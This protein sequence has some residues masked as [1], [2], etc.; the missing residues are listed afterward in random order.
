[1][2]HDRTGRLELSLE[3]QDRAPSLAAVLV[4]QQ[5]D[6]LV[7]ADWLPATRA[8]QLSHAVTV[9]HGPGLAIGGQYGVRSVVCRTLW[10]CA[11]VNTADGAAEATRQLWALGRGDG[12]TIT[13]TK[14]LQELQDG[15]FAYLQPRGQWGYSNAGLI[16]GDDGSLLVDTL[17]DL[18]LTRDMLEEMKPITAT[19]PIGSVVNT[20]ANG[21]HCFGN[22]LVPDRATIYATVAATAEMDEAPPALLDAMKHAPDEEIAAFARHAFGDFDFTDITGRAPDETFERELTLSIGGREVL[23]RDLGP[24]HTQSDSIV[25][26]PSARTVFTGDLAFIGGTP[27]AWAGPVTNWIRACDTIAALDVDIVVP[28]H[29]P[30]SDVKGVLDVKRY[31]EHVLPEARMRWEGGMNAVDA[32][33]D[34][35]LGEFAALSDSERI[36]VTVDTIYSDLDPSRPRADKVELFRLMGRYH[37]QHRG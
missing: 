37:T 32:A 5:H 36:V 4:K 28:G 24:A 8:P 20:H 9:H 15:L 21:D 7:H 19:R 6:R 35:E 18:K 12:M 23:I 34:I 33:F 10:P 25:V 29:G 1:V 3:R 30:V 13:F 2:K 11:V 14:G 17:F 26:V 27:I 16:A 31:F 22:E